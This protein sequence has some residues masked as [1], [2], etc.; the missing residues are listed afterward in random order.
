MIK[1]ILFVFILSILSVEADTAGRFGQSNNPWPEIRKERIANLLPDAMRRAGIDLWVIVCRENANDPLAMHVGCE[2]AGAPAAVIFYTEGEGFYSAVI[3][4]WGDDSG[5]RESELFDTVIVYPRGEPVWNHVAEKLMNVNPE[6]IGVNSSSRSIADGMSYT[7]RSELEQALGNEFAGRIVSAEEIV[8]EWLSVKLPD[9]IEIMRE[10]A[11][12]TE[13]LQYEVY[14]QVL[15]GK[16]T[17]ADVARYLKKRM[18]ELGFEDAWS[19]AQNPAVNAG[20]DRGHAQPTGRIIRHG[21]IIQID[22]GIKVYGV[23]CTD[24]QRFAYVLRPGEESPPP[25]IVKKWEH[26]K[27]GNRRAFNAMKPGVTGYDVDKAQREYMIAAGSLP[28]IWYTGHPVGY[29][30]HDVGPMLGGAEPLRQPSP[31]VYRVLRPR[32][33]FAFDGFYS[34]EA[35]EN[36]IEGTKTISVEEMAYITE[37]GAEFLI[38]PQNE[39]ILIK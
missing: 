27:E 4:P 3:T 13:D 8:I 6:K 16:T 15:P 35:E 10:A 31:D 9:E 32:Q 33:V 11:R 29:W 12:M 25:Q 39:L 7:Q 17:E 30:A 21:D 28:V 20:L 38:P 26:A 24:I 36:G 37:T 1:C 18:D 23:W 22:F 19:P 2:N 14:A 5:F 34:W